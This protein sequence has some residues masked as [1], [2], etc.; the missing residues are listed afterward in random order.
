MT[1]LLDK[2][3]S[4]A[5]RAPASELKTSREVLQAFISRSWRANAERQI[6]KGVDLVIGRREG[7]T[8]WDL[9]GEKAVIDC[10]TGGGVHTLGHRHPE[11]LS[12]LQQSLSES[13]D[14][15]LWSVPSRDYLALQ[16]R[17]AAL[18]PWSGLSKSVITLS[19]TLS[20]EVAAMFAFRMTGRKKIAAYRHGYHGHTG[21]A[22][23]VTGS[24]DEGVIDHYKLPQQH[25]CFFE[26][27]GD[28]ADVAAVLTD[29]VAA[30]IMEPMDYETFGFAAPSFLHGVQ[31]LCRERGVLLIIDETRTGIGR[32]GTL[33]AIENTGLEPDMMITGKGLSGGLYPVSAILVT[34]R[35][36]ERCMNEHRF[37]YISSLG[38]N[39][40]SCVVASKVLEVA[41]RK[42]TLEHAA[43]IGVLLRNALE[44]VA[45]RHPGVLGAVAGR[46]CIATVAVAERAVAK[47]LYSAMYANGVLCHSVSELEPA[48][49]KMFPPVVMTHS[50][51]EQIAEALE[52]SV[53]SVKQTGVG[54]SAL[55]TA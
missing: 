32:T 50:D 1:E 18:A 45:A 40:I 35:I 6:N 22:A 44:K 51:V 11:V 33:W 2:T 49:L 30:L 23:L 55:A 52:R 43:A 3:T 14:T 4:A 19:S 29:D 53:Q 34:E 21:F 41:S 47:A 9:E 13:R 54:N 10:G 5:L 8:L 27:Y 39:E 7:V 26:H 17:L 25:S 37:S 20:V 31:A 36:Y 38:G 16:D 24:P 28:I 12:A 46:G 48:S 15:G 42:E